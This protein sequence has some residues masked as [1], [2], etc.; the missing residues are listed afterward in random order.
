MDAAGLCQLLK[1]ILEQGGLQTPL[2]HEEEHHGNGLKVV[3]GRTVKMDVFDTEIR[4]RQR[5]FRLVARMNP[6]S[7]PVS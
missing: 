4:M 2:S 5:I 3:R 1:T 6:I 7:A